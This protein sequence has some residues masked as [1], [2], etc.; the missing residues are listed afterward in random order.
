MFNSEILAVAELASIP[1]RFTSETYRLG[2]PMLAGGSFLTTASEG[3]G[4]RPVGYG[5]GPFGRSAVDGGSRL[6][7]R[8][9][10]LV[11]VAIA[12]VELASGWPNCFCKI[13]HGGS[14]DLSCV[15]SSSLLY[16][17]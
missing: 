9:L 16:A 4:F 8:Y 13:Q 2:Q 10:M 5:M 17:E 6:V 15:A 3:G 11:D 14:L 12:A 1:R 7:R